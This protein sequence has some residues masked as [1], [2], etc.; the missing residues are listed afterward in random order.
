MLAFRLS[1]IRLDP[2]LK[3]VAESVAREED[4]QLSEPY[5]L[6][7]VERKGMIAV[8]HIPVEHVVLVSGAVCNVC[9][10]EVLSKQRHSRQRV[11]F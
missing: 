8:Q 7:V 3:G 5:K 2:P 9:I 10:A 4:G 1:R 6:T 11:Q